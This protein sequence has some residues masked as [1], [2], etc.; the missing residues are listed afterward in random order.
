MEFCF[1]FN[2]TIQEW[3][4]GIVFAVLIFIAVW[5]DRREG[6]R[7]KFK[8]E[9]RE[10]KKINGKKIKDAGVDKWI[11]HVQK[12]PDYLSG[13]LIMRQIFNPYILFP[14]SVL[15][16]WILKINNVETGL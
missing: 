8:K 10:E 12:R 1:L 2:L 7:E 9:F 14:L 6:G 16:F 13:G 11:Y 4:I 5:N 15:L 3:I